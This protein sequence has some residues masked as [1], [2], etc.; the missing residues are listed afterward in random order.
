MRFGQVPVDEAAGG[1]LVHSLQTA[2][3]TL[4]K[5]HHLTA[6]DVTAIREAGHDTLTVARLEPDEV[7]ED[8]AAA[9][10]AGAIA[11]AC[12]EAAEASTGRANLFA[13]SDG[14][15]CLDVQRLQRL[16]T[17]DESVTIATLP[18]FRPVRAGEMVATVKII[19]FAVP[20]TSLD[21]VSAVAAGTPDRPITVARFRPR[22]VGLVQ[23]ELP[24]IKATTLDKTARVTANRLQALGSRLAAERRTAHTAVEVARAIAAHLEG[25]C[26][27]ILL[28]GAS[29]VTDRRDV[30]PAAIDRVGGTVVHLGMPVDPGNLLVLGQ[31]GEVPVLGLP[32][33]ARAPKENGFDWVLWRIL[34]DRPV[35]PADIMAMGVGGLIGEIPTRPAPRLGAG[36]S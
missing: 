9:E 33:C 29:A 7:P 23:T 13:T 11:G 1:V 22:D 6:E 19:P 5:G 25:G 15:L 26:D 18:P 32:G 17:V 36:R 16:N 30:L 21:V 4:R 28:I 35:T 34:A 20:R 27:L 24:T 10:V 8:A 3:R 31:I 2:D 12:V 14:L